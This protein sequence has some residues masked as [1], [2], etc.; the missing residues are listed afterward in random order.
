[1]AD[2]PTIPAPKLKK[3]QAEE[4]KEHRRLF[5][6]SLTCTLP[7]VPGNDYGSTVNAMQAPLVVTGALAAA[8]GSK[9]MTPSSFEQ[10]LRTPDW[11]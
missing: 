4:K 3:K 5:R 2:K 10:K 11:L 7:R 9:R 6:C 1:V 8:P